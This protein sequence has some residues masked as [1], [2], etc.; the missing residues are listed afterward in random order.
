[1]GGHTDVHEEGRSGRPTVVSDDLFQ[2][3]DQKSVKDGA[4]KF[5]TFV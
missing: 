4:S 2:S 3:I 1:M 5:G